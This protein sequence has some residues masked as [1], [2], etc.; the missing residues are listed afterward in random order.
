[1]LWLHRK[2]NAK[3]AS[4]HQLKRSYQSKLVTRWLWRTTQPGSR[5]PRHLNNGSQEPGLIQ[6]VFAALS[7]AETPPAAPEEKREPAVSIRSSVK[8]DAITCLE[9]GVRMKRLKRHLAT[10][11]GLSPN[12]YRARWCLNADYP[13]VAPEYAGRRRELAIGFGLGR[14]PGAPAEVAPEPAKP[15]PR[16][17]KTANPEE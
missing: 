15:A 4:G 5:P 12:E 6:I 14:K 10:D 11:H 8:H 1:M 7:A 9:C 16:K 3:I 17:R 13:M 2:S